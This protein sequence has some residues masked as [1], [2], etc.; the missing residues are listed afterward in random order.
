MHAF[1]SGISVDDDGDDDVDLTNL[2]D[3]MVMLCG[4]LMILMP[5]ISNLQV[6]QAE[7]AETGGKPADVAISDLPRLEFMADGRMTWND[8]PLSDS[9]LTERVQ[10]LPPKSQ[11]LLGGDHRAT[12]GQGLRIR[13][14]LQNHDI[15]VLEL[16]K[17]I[18]RETK[19]SESPVN[20]ED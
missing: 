18:N 2:V 13:S 9:Q 17:P 14:E 15:E 12:Y 3:P 8:E 4:L 11:V 20:K 19:D 10:Q 7:L 1:Q 5:T 16:V 6:R